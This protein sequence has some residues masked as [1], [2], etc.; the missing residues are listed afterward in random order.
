MKKIILMAIALTLA[1]C[2][3]QA[4]KKNTNKTSAKVPASAAMSNRITESGATQA[5]E[6]LELPPADMGMEMPLH[7]AL[8]SRHSNRMISEEELPLEFVSS[9]LWAAYGINRPEESRR[10]VPSA[11]NMQE[12]DV[13]LFNREGIYLY[14]AAKNSLLMVAKGDHRGE[15]SEQKFFAVAPVVVVLAANYDRM[16]RLKD[17]VD[18]DFFAAIDCGYVSQNIYLYCASANLATVAC[19]AINRDKVAEILDLKN[20]RVLLAHPVGMPIR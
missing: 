8:I 17:P 13:Y 3:A 2:G 5:M 11:I 20:G 18:R 6:V 10:V 9:L 7:K 19:A 16:E 1:V 12:L 15:V 14:D 4:Q